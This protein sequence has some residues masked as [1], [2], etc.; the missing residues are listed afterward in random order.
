[1]GN[2]D[3][4]ADVHVRAN[5]EEQVLGGEL[6]VGPHGEQHGIGMSLTSREVVLWV[7]VGVGSLMRCPPRPC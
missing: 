2:L 3:K 1:M 4:M 6:G 5:G 7:R